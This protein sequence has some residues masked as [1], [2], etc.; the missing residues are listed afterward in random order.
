LGKADGTAHFAHVGGALFGIWSVSKYGTQ[1]N[2]V[3]RFINIFSD[4]FNKLAKFFSKKK[5]TV[6]SNHSRPKTDE[7]FLQDKKENQVK[8]D[9][10]LDKISKAGYDSLNKEEKDILFK[11]SRK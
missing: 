10:I 5:M 11:Q 4:L 2:I 1:K 3:T 9:K 6:V 8:I 7:E